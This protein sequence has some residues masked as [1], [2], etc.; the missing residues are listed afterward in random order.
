[1]W[2]QTGSREALE[3]SLKKY[4][5][6]RSA[7][8][9]IVDISKP[10][11]KPDITV[12][13][14]PHLR[15]HW[16]DRLP[17]IDADIALVAKGL[18]A[19]RT[20]SGSAASAIQAALARP[21]RSTVDCRHRPAGTFRPGEPLPLELSVAKSASPLSARVFYRHV[22]QAERYAAADMELRDG[23]YHA[24]IPG[25]YTNSPYPLEYYFELK[26]G[27]SSSFLYPGFA[28]DRT[29]QPYFVIRRA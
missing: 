22:T 18:E 1:V 25:T 6:A 16:A 7:W 2:E 15:G 4:R 23:A 21:K 11:Y 28:A 27:A 13:E 26:Q 5:E 8:A 14:L 20:A 12:G 10:V 24:T 3:A 17:A 29:N 19:Q 9:E